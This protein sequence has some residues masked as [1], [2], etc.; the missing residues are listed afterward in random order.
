MTSMRVDEWH[1]SHCCTGV[2]HGQLA[3]NRSKFG[4]RS[5]MQTFS[6]PS[7]LSRPVQ[8]YGDWN[9]VKALNGGYRAIEA[10]TRPYP[11]AA[12]DKP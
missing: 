6:S 8:G 3:V 10:T 5:K 7:D 12:S 11:H 9:G 1:F 2:K 4:V